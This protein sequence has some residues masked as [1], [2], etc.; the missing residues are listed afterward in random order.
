MKRFLILCVL[1][2][3]VTQAP[4]ILQAATAASTPTE[5]A[6][7]FS[8]DGHRLGAV[9]KVTD[10]GSAELIYEGKLVSIPAGTLSDVNGKLTTQLTKM[11]VYDLTKQI[12][13]GEGG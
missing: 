8:E 10:D 12:R 2:G 7:L 1:G 3:A 9:Y 11:Q 4:A 13:E 5:G 6:L